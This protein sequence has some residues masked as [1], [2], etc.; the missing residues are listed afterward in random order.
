ML[1]RD[2]EIVGASETG[3]DPA[4]LV[5]RIWETWQRR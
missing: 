1:E 4:A 3:E 5:E 2:G